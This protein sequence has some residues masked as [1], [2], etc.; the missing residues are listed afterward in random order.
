MEYKIIHHC[1]QHE[2]YTES[3]ERLCETFLQNKGSEEASHRTE[4]K[5]KTCCKTGL[6]QC[7][8]KRSIKILSR[9]IVPTSIPT[10]H[11]I[12]MKDKRINGFTQQGKVRFGEPDALSGFSPQ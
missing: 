4:N 8:I 10:W 1:Q 3:K 6:S 9:C 7:H 12:P 5:V 2:H 11:M